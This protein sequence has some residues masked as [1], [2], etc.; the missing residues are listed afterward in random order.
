[1]TGFGKAEAEVRGRK[2]TIE[3]RSL[4]SRQTD[5][6]LKIPGIF[7]DKEMEIRN[8]LSQKLERGKIDL[9][10]TSD[11]SDETSN[12]SINKNLAKRYREELRELQSE[13]NE[14]EMM[15]LLPLILRLPDVVQS[16]RDVLQEGE[17]LIVKEA[18]ERS[19]LLLDEFRIHEGSI[20]DEDMRS[21]TDLI[22]TLLES[23]GPFE[24]NRIRFVKDKLRREFRNMIEGD[25]GSGIIDENRFEQELIYYLERMDITEEKVRLKKH[26]EYF[27]ET[28]NIG[29]SQGKKLG[30]IT[31]EIGREINTIGSKANDA[32]IQKIVVQ[33]KD[34]L[35]KIKEQLLNIL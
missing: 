10:I 14:E 5:I 30:F 17:W 16:G 9:Y 6:S 13:L 27:L 12:Y 1:M 31:Q 4:N 23:I 26:C 33:M 21:R 35:E 11:S 24:S 28:L 29:V 2:F 19:V 3:I 7:R 20:L 22:L 34:E 8:F 18:F 15:G 32:D 25:Q